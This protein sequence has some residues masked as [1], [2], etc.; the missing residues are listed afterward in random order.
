MA[1]ALCNLGYHAWWGCDHVSDYLG[2]AKDDLVESKLM[3]V[4]DTFYKQELEQVGAVIDPYATSDC[5]SRF[6][7][8]MRSSGN[9]AVP[10]RS[11]MQ[12]SQMAIASLL[13]ESPVAEKPPK[14]LS[15]MKF[16]GGSTVEIAENLENV[17]VWG[18][19]D[20][21]GQ[22]YFASCILPNVTA[23]EAHRRLFK[24]TGV[25]HVY[26]T[27]DAPFTVLQH[28]SGDARIEYH[29]IPT[30]HLLSAVS[31]FGFQFDSR[32]AVVLVHKATVTLPNK[33][34]CHIVMLKSVRHPS[35]VH[36]GETVA[37]AASMMK[38]Y[39]PGK[40]L[41]NAHHIA[42]IVGRQQRA[43][44]RLRAFAFYEDPEINKTVCTCFGHEDDA[45]AYNNLGKAQHYL[46][47]GY[48]TGGVTDVVKYQ[49]ERL[50]HILPS[51]ND[52]STANFYATG[53]FSS[54][55]A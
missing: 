48:S 11:V 27:D 44:I 3:P 26:N 41:E 47:F 6:T 5:F 52:A 2:E 55:V 30:G 20:V 14:W 25:Q 39:A 19:N 34:K 16:A 32:E 13:S 31:S 45:G 42:G 1:K 28:L 9:H 23:D 15:D 10:S 53:P 37:P 35:V 7:S 46:S 54:T 50:S 17:R 8:V 4:V 33:A 12:A 36:E 49:F 29:H 21:H 40:K 38:S 51:N 24:T 18:R 22:Q 43:L